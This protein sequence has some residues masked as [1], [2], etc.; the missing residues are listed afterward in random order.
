MGVYEIFLPFVQYGI[1]DRI[2]IGGGGDTPVWVTPKVQVI[3]M[4]STE[5]AFY[6]TPISRRGLVRQRPRVKSGKSTARLRLAFDDTL[7]ST[8]AL[9][10]AAS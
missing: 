7:S 2:S 6:G 9:S 4:K 1:T 3:K 8:T 10:A 5:A